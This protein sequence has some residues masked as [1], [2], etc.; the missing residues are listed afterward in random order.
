LRIESVVTFGKTPAVTLAAGAVLA[1]RYRL[2]SLVGKGG[3]GEVWSA[4]HLVTGRRVAIK[5]L[6]VTAE[7]DRDGNARARFVRE[8]RAACAV[9]HPNVVEVVDFLETGGEPTLVMELLSGK[10]LADL[11][12]RTPKLGVERTAQLLLPVVSAVGT[13]HSLGIVH[14]DLKPANIY[15]H[16]RAGSAP[17]VKVLDFGMAK[18]VAWHASASDPRTRAGFTLGTP[19]YMAPEQASGRTITHR[20]DVWALGVVLYQCLSGSRP[21]EGDNV[22]DVLTNLQKKGIVPIEKL[23]P[24]LPADLARLIG[25]ML[26]RD[27]AERT[28]DLRETFTV[29]S[30][31]AAST[32][33][34]FGPP[35]VD[36]VTAA[37]LPTATRVA[38][39]VN[40][41][42]ARREARAHQWR[43]NLTFAAVAVAMLGL[44]ALLT[45]GHVR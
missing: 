37:E 21:V 13:A 16:E 41:A 9:N 29:L 42:L 20:V 2:S 33:P 45:S 44:L 36:L 1:E 4:V 25:R 18:W 7:Q 30:P 14:R 40:A 12:R 43:R 3:V 28:P 38:P 34:A 22:A 26:R 11:L 8:A 32:A 19:S 39:S 35:D 27:P 23:V 15:L 17:L 10:T 24:A 5:R 31:Y 6:L